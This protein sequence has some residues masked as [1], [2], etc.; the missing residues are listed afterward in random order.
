M[1]QIAGLY[2]ALF[3]ISLVWFDFWLNLTVSLLGLFIVIALSLMVDNLH[4]TKAEQEWVKERIGKLEEGI[5]KLKIQLTEREEK[6]GKIEL[7]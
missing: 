1:S 6:K 4:E 3:V 2:A 5:K 7:L